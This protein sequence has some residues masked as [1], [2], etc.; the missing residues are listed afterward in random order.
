M[1]RKSTQALLFTFIILMGTWSIVRLIGADKPS[2]FSRG[3]SSL[4]SESDIPSWKSYIASKLR[5]SPQEAHVV[6]D[7]FV[8]GHDLCTL[9]RSVEVTF[10]AEG[11]AY[12]G[13]PSRLR[14]TSECEDLGFTQ[15]WPRE[16]MEDHSGIQ[17]IGHFEDEPDEW[18]LESIKLMGPHGTLILSGVEI[19]QSTG[20]VFIIETST[21][22]GR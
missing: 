20:I 4:Q 5:L 16:L 10:R 15:V 22:A 3:P 17:K 12:S 7:L 8:E 9:W 6:L 13:E 19:F 21:I 2:P 18:G 11:I 14:Q 1:K